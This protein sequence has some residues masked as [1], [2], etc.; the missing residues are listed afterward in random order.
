VRIK[1][2]IGEMNMKKSIQMIVISAI[3]AMTTQSFAYTNCTL[4][5][6]FMMFKQSNPNPDVDYKVS[7]K[8]TSLTSAIAV[9]D[10]IEEGKSASFKI[11]QYGESFI[12]Q[13][14]GLSRDGRYTLLLSTPEGTDESGQAL[15]ATATIYNGASL[16]SRNLNTTFI[17]GQTGS[18]VGNGAFIP[19]P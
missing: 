15:P 14:K 18:T 17:Q 11:T 19:W 12:R 8:N 3:F 6:T 2:V 10:G 5:N 9:V 1:K 7:V 16:N 13:C 4:T